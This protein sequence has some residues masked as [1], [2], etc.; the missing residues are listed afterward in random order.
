[1]QVKLNVPVSAGDGT[2]YAVL[3]VTGVPVAGSENVGIG[4]SLGVTSLIQMA[5]TVQTRSGKIQDLA[6]TKPTTGEPLAATGTLRNLGN[7]HFGAVPNQVVTY[8]SIQDSKG[9][10]I[11]TSKATMAG[12]SLV[13][14]F[15]R[16]FSVPL[17][18]DRPMV[19]G[20]YH[21]EVESRLQDGTVL[22][23]AALD[24]DITSGAVAGE[25][26]VP[27]VGQ[28]AAGGGGSSTALL[29]LVG[30]LLGLAVAVLLFGVL[31]RR[32]RT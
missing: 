30:V 6:V 23:R 9:E 4:L 24:F 31:L 1:V 22:D 2:R 12:N 7:S 17:Q 32:R 21:L 8:A 14:T 13:P 25:T 10:T 5:K 3:K 20:R 28:P 18:A 11:A 16:Q 29:V 27:S 15:G 26:A 19:D